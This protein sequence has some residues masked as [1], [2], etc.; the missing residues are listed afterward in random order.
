MI[1]S[2][3][4]NFIF[5]KTRKTAGTSI[6]LALSTICGPDDVITPLL[7]KEEKMRQEMGGVGPYNYRIPFRKYRI[8]DFPLGLYRRKFRT[9][10]NHVPAKYVRQ[11]IDDDIWNSYYKF[12]FERNPYDKIVSWYYWIQ[13]HYDP[14][15]IS[16]FIRRVNLKRIQARYQYMIDDEIAMNKIY[17]YEELETAMTDLSIHLKLEKPL[18]LAR[19]KSKVRP[20]KTHYRDLLTRDDKAII[21]ELFAMEL[22]HFNYT[23]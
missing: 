12:C 15:T 20:S 23:W 14:M 6:E 5:I 22:E 13:E 8:I 21:D 3:K 7:P 17:R 11:Y 1:I 2:H 9:F 10:Y 4:H 18:Q 16:E 19:A